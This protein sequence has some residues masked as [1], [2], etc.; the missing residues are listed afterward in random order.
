MLPA[1]RRSTLYGMVH[2]ISK[3]PVDRDDQ[4]AEI[5]TYQWPDILYIHARGFLE[6]ATIAAERS[7]KEGAGIDAVAP[8]IMSA[9]RH[10][11]ELFL[12]YVIAELADRH[13]HDAER[14]R[15]G[16]RVLELFRSELPNIKGALECEAA[17]LLLTGEFGSQ[18]LREC[19]RRLTKWIQ[20]GRGS[21]IHSAVTDRQ[22]LEASYR[23]ALSSW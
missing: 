5:T 13:E 15:Q 8:A 7:L 20:M 10:A 16:H 21:G 1:G 3:S 22:T 6:I 18:P 19:S 23:R 9:I 12:K 11:A 14:M 2:L 17:P 4:I